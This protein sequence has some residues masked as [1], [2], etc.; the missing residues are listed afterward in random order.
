MA[1]NVDQRTGG[2]ECEILSRMV[3]RWTRAGLVGFIVLSTVSCDQWSKKVAQDRLLGVGR[4]SYLEDLFRLEYAENSGAFLS[5]GAALP[6]FLRDLLLTW[7][8]GLVLCGVLLVALAKPRVIAAQVVGYSLVAGGGVSNLF[9]RI[10]RHG[11][12][13]DFM[14]LGIGR[15]RTGIFNVA[16]LAIVGGVIALILVP[17]NGNSVAPAGVNAQV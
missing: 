2:L 13:I 16:D 17:R 10:A 3:S 1:L 14:N 15:I 6:T 11:Y 7:G 8:V 12:V 9:D 5:L 4:L